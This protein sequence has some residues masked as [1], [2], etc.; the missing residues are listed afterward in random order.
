MLA[1]LKLMFVMTGV[2]LRLSLPSCFSRGLIELIQ[3]SVE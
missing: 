2:L 3:G 1:L